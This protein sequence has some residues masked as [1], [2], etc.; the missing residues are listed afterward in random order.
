MFLFLISDA[1]LRG[2]R[3][4]EKYFPL[5]RCQLLRHSNEFA[6]NAEKVSEICRIAP[7]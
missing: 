4:Q 5:F 6:T 1:K 3:T 7:F 2:L